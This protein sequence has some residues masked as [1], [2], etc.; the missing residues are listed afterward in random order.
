DRFNDG[1][2]LELILDRDLMEP[3]VELPNTTFIL[4]N[5]EKFEEIDMDAPRKSSAGQTRKLPESPPPNR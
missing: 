5:T 3:D 2:K 4:E 1:Y